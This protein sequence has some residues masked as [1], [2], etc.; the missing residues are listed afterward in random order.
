[1]A[2]QELEAYQKKKDELLEEIDRLGEALKRRLSHII[3][4]LHYYPGNEGWVYLVAPSRGPNF[5]QGRDPWHVFDLAIWLW[6]RG[7]DIEG[8]YGLYVTRDELTEIAT[9]L[10]LSGDEGR[11]DESELRAA[12]S[13]KPEPGLREPGSDR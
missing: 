5:I 13:R 7:F 1:M 9:A 6:S 10:E 12:E 11:S 8:P 4:D 2:I 3:P